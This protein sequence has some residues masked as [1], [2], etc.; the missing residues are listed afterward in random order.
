MKTLAKVILAKAYK[1]TDFQN[2]KSFKKMA[3]IERFL[4]KTILTWDEILLVSSL[5]IY[6]N[7]NITVSDI[8]TIA[9]ATI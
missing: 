1:T 8:K 6:S 4:A 7:K 9:T 5:N 2:E 3:K